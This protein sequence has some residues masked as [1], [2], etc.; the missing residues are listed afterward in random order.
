MDIVLALLIL[1]IAFII[2]KSIGIS[3]WTLV[4]VCI[5]AALIVYVFRS[6][7]DM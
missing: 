1:L 3:L 5:V 4:G 2:I 7:R 6:T